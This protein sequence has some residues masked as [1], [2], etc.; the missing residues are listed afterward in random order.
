M[1]E[2]DRAAKAARA[3]ALVDGHLGG[4]LNAT[5][6]FPDVAGQ[7]AETKEGRRRRRGA[8]QPTIEVDDTSSVRASGGGREAGRS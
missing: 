4:G 8:Y 7:T 1:S 6:G 3:K 5:D 2:D